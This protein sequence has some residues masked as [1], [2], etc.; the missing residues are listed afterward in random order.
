VFIV[1]P[2][3]EISRRTKSFFVVDS[4]TTRTRTSGKTEKANFLGGMTPRG[5]ACMR[6]CSHGREC[7]LSR[8]P[9][10]LPPLATTSRRRRP[11]FRSHQGRDRDCSRGDCGCHSG[12]AGEARGLSTSAASTPGAAGCSVRALDP[13]LPKAPAHLAQSRCLGAYRG[14]EAGTELSDEI[15]VKGTNAI[16]THMGPQIDQTARF[17]RNKSYGHPRVA[18]PDDIDQGG[19]LLGADL[20]LGLS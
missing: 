6:Y 10:R 19:G 5:L 16:N 2:P 15:D 1:E 8:E 18:H 4:A 11:S 14:L 3:A 9:W 12:G 7:C 20:V 13:P 17:K